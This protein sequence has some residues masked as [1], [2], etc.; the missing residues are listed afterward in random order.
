MKFS[1]AFN[2]SVGAVAISG[3]FVAASIASAADY[4]V[5]PVKIIVSY[6]AGGITDVYARKFAEKL[7][8]RLKQPFLIENKPGAAGMI[9]SEQVAKS[10]A[11]GYTLTY[12][13]TAT[14]LPVILRQSVKDPSVELL[15]DFD[16]VSLMSIG[17]FG[18]IINSNVPAKNLREF[19][20]YIKANP[21]KFFYGTSSGSGKMVM[22]VFNKA[23]GINIQ[24]VPYKGTA[25]LTTALVAG[26]VT[27]VLE[28]TVTYKPFLEN[29]RL[30]ALA[31]TGE[32]R[33]G[34]LPD[35]PTLIESGYPTIK[36]V[37]SG[38]FWGPK[39]LPPVVVGT[40]SAPLMEIAKLPDI[41]EM[42]RSSGSDPIGSTPEGLRQQAVTENEFWTR[43]AQIANIPNAQ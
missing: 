24:H 37:Y 27:A 26:E 14:L 33:P 35:T 42:I 4:P 20:D 16:P 36:G 40:L 15:R 23:A 43:A 29:G 1:L 25:P 17:A 18:L 9:G 30:R 31:T 5:K 10:A 32:K 13:G 7:Q 3:L 21:G 12:V 41:V 11:D 34:T 8:D 2:L 6:P 38:G 22:E 28:P 19:V 39:G